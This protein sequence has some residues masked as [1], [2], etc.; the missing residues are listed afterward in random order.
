MATV[1]RRSEA[2]QAFVLSWSLVFRIAAVLV[3]LFLAFYHLTR[4]PT[5]WFDEGTVLNASKT[6]YQ[7]HVY[8]EHS[9]DGFNYVGSIISVGP[10]V[11]VP[12]SGL[13]VLFGA[14]L[15]Q[16]RL[17]AVLY[18]LGTIAAFWGMSRLV[19]GSRLA[20]V[21]AALLVTSR[22]V[23]LLEFGRQ[24]L[25]EV[26][27]LFFTAAGL[28]LWFNAWER[29]N[30][31][32]LVGAGIL[33]GLAMVTK[34]EFLLFLAPTMILAWLANLVYYR[35]A[36]QRVFLIP[37]II[38]AACFAVWLAFLVINQNPATIGQNIASLRTATS[39]A[40][41]V[42]SLSLMK[43]SIQQLLALKVYLSFLAPVMLYGFTLLL[44]RRREAHRWFVLFTF[45]SVDLVWYAVASVGWLRYA[46]PGLA[47]ASVFVAKF[48]Y[49]LTDGY[50]LDLSAIWTSLRSRSLLP[51][52]L[53]LSAA[54][55][56][57]LFVMI[58]LP[59]GQTA[60]DILTPQFDAPAAMAAYIDQNVPQAAL[61]ETWEPEMGFL[62]NNNYHF[63]PQILLNTAVQYISRG[64]QPPSNSYHFLQTNKPEYVL[65]GQFASW[66]HLY[67]DD[68]LASQYTLEKSIG[69]YA[70]YRLNK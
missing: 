8:A 19:G 42:F 24:A 5:T 35:T 27:G 36:P 55:L 39:G 50:K 62:T 70:L 1:S 68:I 18:L 26:P 61:I 69:A 30:W 32:K 64:G 67:P 51:A 33:L 29:P 58:V 38:S 63:P 65:I 59:L 66:V 37:G 47:F 20:W 46:F 23:T 43:Q 44:P 48:F 56:S 60:R 57:W 52:K 14:G 4:F 16:A 11:M 2:A 40:A 41:L 13:F 22:G 28:W 53:A 17:I 34:Y 6:F 25:G 3:V 21:A 7:Y 15:L 54:L 10:T 12:I 9:S 45:I 49:D 31:K